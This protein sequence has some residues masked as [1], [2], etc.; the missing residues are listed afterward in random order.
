MKRKQ[1][2]LVS[3]LMMVAIFLSL[4]CAS[5]PA[6]IYSLFATETS[7]PTATSTATS[8]PTETLTPSPTLTPTDT[9]TPTATNTF[10]PTST[11]TNTSTPKPIYT[12]VPASTSSG[13]GGFNLT[14]TV[15]NKCTNQRT[16]T[17]T[18]PTNLKFVLGSGQSQSQKAVQGTYKWTEQVNSVVSLT[19]GPLAIYTTAWTLT[20]CS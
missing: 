7:T 4:S 11:A 20:L 2:F 9:A 3:F 15:I 10:T 16:V 5:I 12:Y 1:R 6:G 19:F 13:S 14:I 18:G 8:T 17:F